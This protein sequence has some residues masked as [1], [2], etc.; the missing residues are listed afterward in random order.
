MTSAGCRCAVRTFH[1]TSIP[2]ALAANRS[3]PVACPATSEGE[4]LALARAW[5]EERTNRRNPAVLRASSPPRLCTTR[6]AAIQK[7]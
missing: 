5:H 4:N 7:L 1:D 6:P 2:A 3:S